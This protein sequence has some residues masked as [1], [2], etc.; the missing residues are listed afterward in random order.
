MNLQELWVLYEQDKKLENFSKTTL[1]G[2][3]TQCNLLIRYFGDMDIQEITLQKL[4]TYLIE[5]GGHLKP[6]SLG[7]RVRF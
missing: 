6:S 2:Y 5:K 7:M 4:K 3:K 1:K